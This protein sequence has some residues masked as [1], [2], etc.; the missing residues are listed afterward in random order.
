MV[1]CELRVKPYSSVT[2]I[3]QTDQTTMATAATSLTSKSMPFTID[4]SQLTTHY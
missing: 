1:N 3:C 4:Y 2:K